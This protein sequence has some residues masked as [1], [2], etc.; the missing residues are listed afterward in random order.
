[1][2]KES[3]FTILSFWSPGLWLVTVIVQQTF[4]KLQTVMTNCVGIRSFI[5]AAFFLIAILTTRQSQ[6]LKSL[7]NALV[8]LNDFVPPTQPVAKLGSCNF[9]SRWWSSHWGETLRELVNVWWAIRKRQTCQLDRSFRFV[10]LLFQI[11]I[12]FCHFDGSSCLKENKKQSL[13]WVQYKL[14]K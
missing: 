6:V 13:S 4:E 11:L 9:G 3:F 7:K 12:T 2:S 14:R 8:S 5:V 1:M 10:R